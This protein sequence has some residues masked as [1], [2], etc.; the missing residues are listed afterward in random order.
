MS[1]MLQ[2]IEHKKKYYH[3]IKPYFHTLF[4]MDDGIN[5]YIDIFQISIF[6]QFDIFFFLNYYISHSIQS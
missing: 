5:N 3:T 6:F 2:N 4:L 1:T